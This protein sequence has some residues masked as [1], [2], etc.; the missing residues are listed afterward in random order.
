SRRELGAGP[1]NWGAGLPAWSWA[2]LA[3]LL[4]VAATLA[5]SRSQQL[6]ARAAQ[7]RAFHALAT[8]AFNA[9]ADSLHDCEQLLR[10]VQTVFLASGE[11]PGDE[12]PPPY[13]HLPP[14]T[15]L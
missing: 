12:L 4:G 15:L 3:L 5:V 10:S 14:A 7:E 9:V 2:A 6:E 13:Q 8:E 11:L 1:V